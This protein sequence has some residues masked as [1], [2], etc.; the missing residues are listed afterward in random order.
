MASVAFL[1]CLEDNQIQQQALLLAESIREFGGSL[2]DSAIYTFSPRK[3]LA[4]DSETRNLI[5]D[6]DI[7]HV[8]EILNEEFHTF[9]QA[10]KIFITDW[11]ERNLDQEIL[12]FADSDSVFLN[13]PA[14]LVEL[15]GGA[16]VCPAWIPGIASS[17]PS[18]PAD[19][20]WIEA[21]RFCETQPQEPSIR[22]LITREPMRPYFNTGLIAARRS[23]QLFSTWR[24]CLERLHNSPSVMKL[25]K[26]EGEAISKYFRPEYF[27]EQFSFAIAVSKS[28]IDVDLLDGYY[29]CPLHYRSKLSGN[30]SNIDLSG[31]IHIHY[32][33]YFNWPP[34]LTS[35]DPPLD[36]ASRQFRFLAQRTPL[37]PVQTQEWPPAFIDTFNIEMKRWRESLEGNFERS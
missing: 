33:Y 35:F 11:A 19:R 27:L 10:N 24:D 18:D 15:V 4:P 29:N 2:S 25:L 14:K 20:L 7:I 8:D 22:S 37:L 34:F 6:L 3:G 28:G 9:P 16:A 30:L 36:P 17:G 5:K 21:S 31:L 12:I 23:T 13:E 1:I 26:L 32:L